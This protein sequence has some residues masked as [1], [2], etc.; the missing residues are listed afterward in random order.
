MK[1]LNL[2]KKEKN[3]LADTTS[4]KDSPKTQHHYNSQTGELIFMENKLEYVKV[5]IKSL[6]EESKII[7][8]QEQKQKTKYKDI[9][10]RNRLKETNLAVGTKIGKWTIAV[11]TNDRVTLTKAINVKNS[12]H[13]K[14]VSKQVN[15]NW[16]PTEASHKTAVNTFRG[17]REHRV[18]VVRDE[19]RASHIA[20]GF[21]RG[22]KYHEIENAQVAE[23]CHGINGK[24]W[25][26]EY[27]FKTRILPRVQ[28][29][30]SK[31]SKDNVTVFP[32]DIEKWVISSS[33]QKKAA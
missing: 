6:A 16:N 23:Y 18:T 5:K 15:L 14:T 19:A 27:H 20:Y 2:F 26:F 25:H 33:E 9:V 11:I 3:V 7:R 17:L 31:Y 32:E 24:Q 13:Q 21:L 4:I 28:A 30:A 10:L 12:E 1:L 22:K 29:I 8:A